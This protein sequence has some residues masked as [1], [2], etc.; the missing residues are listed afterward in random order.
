MFK[1]GKFVLADPVLVNKS[2][3]WGN[4]VTVGQ[5]FLGLNLD[6]SVKIIDIACG[7]GNVAAELVNAGYTNID[8]LDP[9]KGYLEVAKDRNIFQQYFHTSVE[10]GLIHLFKDRHQCKV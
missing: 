10:P 5:V 9:I 2:M 8:G 6:K 3:A 4:R 7:I 1:K